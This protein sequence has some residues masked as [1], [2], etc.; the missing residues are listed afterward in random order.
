MSHIIAFFLGVSFATKESAHVV[1]NPF[2]LYISADTVG[3]IF[4]VL[5]LILTPILFLLILFSDEK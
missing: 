4:Y 3:F 1:E 5:T 2:S